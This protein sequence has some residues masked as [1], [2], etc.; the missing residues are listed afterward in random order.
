MFYA[1]KFPN[2]AC[3]PHEAQ[4]VI[5]EGKIKVFESIP[6]ALVFISGRPSFIKIPEMEARDLLKS[7]FQVYIGEA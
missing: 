4:A 6:E 2:K 1:Y 3:W 5:S 7:S